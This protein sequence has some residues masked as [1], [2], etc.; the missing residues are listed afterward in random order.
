MNQS[1]H[2]ADKPAS[3][4]K[5]DGGRRHVERSQRLLGHLPSL[6]WASGKREG[7][8]NFTRLAQDQHYFIAEK[9]S[10]LGC[11]LLAALPI[12]KRGS[13]PSGEACARP[14]PK[15]ASSRQAHPRTIRVR[16]ALGLE[17][18]APPFLNS[19]RRVPMNKAFAH[20]A[21]SFG[22]SSTRR[23]AMAGTGRS[24][25]AVNNRDCAAGRRSSK[26]LKPFRRS[27]VAVAYR[28]RRQR[29]SRRAKS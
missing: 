10:F 14:L 27:K 15:S 9:I 28:T 18:I 2:V 29:S 4:K 25:W 12:F 1:A 13:A 24:P 26:Q 5:P 16:A 19:N 20:K 3:A 7:I 23:A 17:F 11:G 6:V 22:P 21:L 8:G